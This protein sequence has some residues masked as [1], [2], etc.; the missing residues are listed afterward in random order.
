MAATLVTSACGDGALTEFVPPHNDGS[1]AIEAHNPS[2]QRHTLGGSISGLDRAGLVLAN[3][4]DRL[5]VAAHT[6]SFVFPTPLASA[7]GYTVT[8]VSQ[9]AGRLCSVKN[10]S[11]AMPGNPVA[12]V[13]VRCLV[14]ADKTEPV[15]QSS[16]A[17]LVLL[18]VA[19]SARSVP[20]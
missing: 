13:K 1:A 10:G 9:P 2:S 18:G 12:N 19:R 4:T 15:G 11:G 17:L 6:S 8:V 14:S 7:E 3:G 16:R 20:F 5:L